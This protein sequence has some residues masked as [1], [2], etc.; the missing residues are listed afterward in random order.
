MKKSDFFKED[1]VY[2]FHCWTSSICDLMG[3]DVEYVL[4]TA[5]VWVKDAPSRLLMCDIGSDM[6]NR[7]GVD[8]HEACDGTTKFLTNEP[9]TF[10][11]YTERTY[12][13]IDYVEKTGGSVTV[14][15]ADGNN[16]TLKPAGGVINVEPGTNYT[17]SIAVSP[18]RKNGH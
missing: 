1:G 18:S 15:L 10:L 7:Y 2:A 9:K 3:K 13:L 14:T 11:A 4:S 6:R 17:L 5:E 16:N 12:D 8:N